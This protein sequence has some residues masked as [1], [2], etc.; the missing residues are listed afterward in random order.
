MG[1]VSVHLYTSKD[2]ITRIRNRVVP[3]PSLASETLGH[4]WPSSSSAPVCSAENIFQEIVYRIKQHHR[5]IAMFPA[6]FI[7]GNRAFE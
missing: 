4:P 7:F 1:K 5:K 2:R 6:I 3:V